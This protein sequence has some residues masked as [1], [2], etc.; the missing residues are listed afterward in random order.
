MLALNQQTKWSSVIQ[1]MASTW[2]AA[3]STGEM[4]S[5]RMSM[6]PLPPSRPREA[7][8]LLT[9]VQQDSRLVLTTSHQLWYQKVTSPRSR[10]PSVCCPT[11]PPSL[12]LGPDLTTSLI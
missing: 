7:S 11:P 3:C 9:G 10:E 8:N 12:R 1:D 6:P 2:P 5:P 4:W